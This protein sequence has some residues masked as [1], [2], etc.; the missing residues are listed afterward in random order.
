MNLF[1]KYPQLYVI[2]IPAI[3]VPVMLVTTFA[4]MGIEVIIR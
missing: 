2:I 3:T 1:K 4:I